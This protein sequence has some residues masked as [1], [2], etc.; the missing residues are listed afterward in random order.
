MIRTSQHISTVILM[1][2]INYLSYSKLFVSAIC[3]LGPNCLKFKG[4]IIRTITASTSTVLTLREFPDPRGTLVEGDVRSTPVHKVLLPS[5]M[6][7]QWRH[8]EYDGASNYRRHD[9]LLNRFLRRRSKK[10]SKLRVNSLCE[11]NH[12]WTV[13]SPHKGPV[14]VSIWWRHHVWC[15]PIL[16]D[17]ARCMTTQRIEDSWNFG[18]TMGLLPD[19]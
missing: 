12:P 16:H 5:S 6:R 17:I 8:N 14:N 9:C 11:G 19:V 7:E 10:T 4:Q 3:A 13:N 1:I 2:S 15:D 18:L